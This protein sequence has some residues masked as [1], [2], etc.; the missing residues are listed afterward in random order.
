MHKIV[1]VSTKVYMKK[2]ASDKALWL[3]ISLYTNKIKSSVRKTSA[4]VKT[5]FQQI[6]RHCTV[7]CL[8]NSGS[9]LGYDLSQLSQ[10]ERTNYIEV[11]DFSFRFTVTTYS[12]DATTVLR[13][14][15]TSTSQ[16]CTGA[17]SKPIQMKNKDQTGVG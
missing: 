10:G 9:G 6:T 2:R 1:A 16:C 7:F 17:A 4:D 15:L 14:S 13:T 8:S 12:T 5:A 11:E 3:T